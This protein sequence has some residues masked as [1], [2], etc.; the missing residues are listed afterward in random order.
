MRLVSDVNSNVCSQFE[1]QEWH[2]SAI[3]IMMVT[4]IVLRVQLFIHNGFKET[5]RSYLFHSLW[6]GPFFWI[7]LFYCQW[8]KNYNQTKIFRFQIIQLY[9][10]QKCCQHTSQ[11][12]IIHYDPTK[13]SPII[14]TAIK[15]KPLNFP[16]I[17]RC[18]ACLHEI[19]DLQAL[20]RWSLYKASCSRRSWPIMEVNNST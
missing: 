17:K 4:E 12:F 14:F 1:R 8:E 13:R 19:R 20:L 11:G 3:F 16:R 7:L 10:F 9:S 6:K 2:N 18:I 5:K 15:N